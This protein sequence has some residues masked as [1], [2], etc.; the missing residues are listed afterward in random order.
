M[1]GE[2]KAR[3]WEGREKTEGKEQGKGMDIRKKTVKERGKTE[4]RRKSKEQKNN[5]MK[6]N[7]K[8]S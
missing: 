2:R 7:K 8:R 4:G 3:S 6:L 5:R 1:E